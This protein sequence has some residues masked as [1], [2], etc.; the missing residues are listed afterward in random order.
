V[1]G[2]GTTQ[3]PQWKGGTGKLP[4]ACKRPTSPRREPL[5]NAPWAWHARI[6]RVVPRR[7]GNH[8]K[9]KN[10]ANVQLCHRRSCRGMRGRG[11]ELFCRFQK[12]KGPECPLGMLPSGPDY[13]LEAE[14]AKPVATD[15]T[16]P[17]WEC[18][19]SREGSG[20]PAMETPR[21]C[22][23]RKNSQTL[24]LRGSSSLPRRLGDYCWGVKE[25]G[26]Q[27]RPKNGPK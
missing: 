17:P 13:R 6:N 7:R 25:G 15:E 12:A 23:H 20:T 19:H 1:R 10:R 11:W 3:L 4:G 9:R 26:P 21:R 22:F 27:I 5:V 16:N 18:T 2:L 8:G 14:G 24:S